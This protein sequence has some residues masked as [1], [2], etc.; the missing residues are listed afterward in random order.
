MQKCS[1]RCALI[2]SGILLITAPVLAATEVMPYTPTAD[3]ATDAR[4][5]ETAALHSWLSSFEGAE[6]AAFEVAPPAKL[7]ELDSHQPDGGPLWIGVDAEIGFTFDGSAKAQP[8]GSIAYADGTM[9]W[10]G[11]F[12]SVGA[13]GVRLHLENLDLP[14]G[15]ELYVYGRHGHAFRPLHGRPS[16]GSLDQHRRGRRDRPAAP[17][18]ARP[19]LV[20]GRQCAVRGQRSSPTSETGTSSA[21][22]WTRLSAAGTTP[23]SQNASSAPRFPSAVQ[24]LQRRRRIPDLR[25][26]VRAARSSARVVCSTPPTSSGDPYLLTANHC[27]STQSAASSLE[28]YF[29]WTVSC[30]ASCGSPVQPAGL[31]AADDR[32]PPSWRPARTPTSPSSSSARRHR[33]VAPSSVGPPPRWPTRRV[34]TCSG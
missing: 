29:Q 23:A 30:G 2:L 25:S 27:F 1:V 32:L 20:G 5:I 4:V 16:Q 11:A 34:P 18:A 22:A 6:K 9:V 24:P 26:W 17:P 19:P 21:T 33:R 7:A 15:A 14:K 31:G 8:L 10:S 28:A 3:K 13:T 12:R